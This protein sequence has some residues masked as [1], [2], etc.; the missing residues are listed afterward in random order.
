MVNGFRYYRARESIGIASALSTHA[1]SESINA[2]S[3]KIGRTLLL[4]PLMV[5]PASQKF[6]VAEL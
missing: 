3:L 4:G 1:R 6:K 2:D 5:L